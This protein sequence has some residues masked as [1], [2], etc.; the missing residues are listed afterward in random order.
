MKTLNK[1]IYALVIAGSVSLTGCDK[2][3]LDVTPND[4][5]TLDNFFQSEADLQA[6]TAGLYNKVWFDFNDKFYYGLGDGRSNNLFAPYSDYIYPF[7]DLTET[8]LTGPLVSAWQSFYNVI[9]QSNNTINNIKKNAKNVTEDQKNAAIAEARFMRGT[10]YWYLA[11]LWGD[12][13][14]IEDNSTLV[15][16]PIVHTNPRKDVFEFAMRDL[17]FAA[18]YLPATVSQAG[19]LTK[20][21]A[22]GMLSRVYLSYSG[23]SSD[24]NSG[25]RD[26]TYLELAKKAAKKVCEE[27]DL[28]LM[29]NYA[30]LFKIENNNNSE[31]LFA[32]QWV[33]NGDYGVTNTQQAYF[34]CSSDIT[35]DD[36]AWG[37][38]TMASYDMMSEYE[39]Q[40]DVRR[41]A[42]F[43][44]YGDYYAEISKAAGGYTY[45][46]ATDRC[47]VKK[48][49]VGSTKD[50]DGKS[51]RMNSALNTYMLRLSEVYLIYAEAIL[52]NNASTAD[53]TALEYFNKVR[54]RAGVP[55]KSSISYED[56][57][58]ERRVEFAMEGQYWYDLVRR[59]Y[60]KQQEVLDMINL[61]DRAHNGSY[62]YDK[63][64]HTIVKA[65]TTSTRAVNQATADRLLLPYPESEMVQNPLLKEAP[66]SYQFKEDRITDLFN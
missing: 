8:S 52:G 50:T 16:N 15:N 29:S 32:L 60:Y 65:T 57:R 24:P 10:A 26:E 64:A 5:I 4:R 20:W 61:Q 30:D 54:T 35:G 38:Y 6:S 66:V 46:K 19:R 33:P 34:A 59:A 48:G 39:A 25:Q 18:K 1:I 21:S 56:I 43:M 40:D 23:I 53:A 58:H 37:Y 12:A 27:S 22:F 9:G 11:S 49:V 2:S 62:T 44:A 13:I 28:S 45:K 63:D 31:S 14:I 36:A 51:S 7:T 55:T 3:F 47:N 17:E 41:K 42:T